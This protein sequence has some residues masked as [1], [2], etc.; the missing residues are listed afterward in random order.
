M[1]V[2]I[3]KE[4]EMGNVFTLEERLQVRWNGRR[5]RVPKGF[6]SDGASV[7]RIFWRLVFP[8]SDTKALRAAFCHDFIYRT[9]PAGWTKEEADQMFYDILVRDGVPRWRAWIAYQGVKWFGGWAWRD[10]GGAA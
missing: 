2:E 6:R 9:H 4:D 5:L 10:M 8:S 3:H 7:P 1:K